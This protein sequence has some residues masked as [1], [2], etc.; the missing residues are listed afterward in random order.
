MFGGG[1]TPPAEQQAA[2]NTVASQAN[3]DGQ[4]SSQ[5]GARNCESDAKNFTKC[6][7]D[8]QGNMQICGWYLEQLVISLVPSLAGRRRCTDV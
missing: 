5:W 2:D 1:S 6:M 8:Y 7:D 4:Q 3:N